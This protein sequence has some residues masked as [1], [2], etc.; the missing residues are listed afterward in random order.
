MSKL[1]LRAVKTLCCYTDK[2]HL[3]F[4]V[5][6][7]HEFGHNWERLGED[8]NVSKLKKIALDYKDRV[9]LCLIVMVDC[10]LRG[11][12]S[13][14]P[15]RPANWNQIVRVIHRTNSTHANHLAGKLS[16]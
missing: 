11:K 5:K 6:A 9:S 7:L 15:G 16:G 8:L 12:V 14:R 13:K 2:G 4:V 1:G 3:R 10:L